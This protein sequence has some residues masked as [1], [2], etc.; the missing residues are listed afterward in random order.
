MNRTHLA[1]LVK[2]GVV[3]QRDASPSCSVSQTPMGVPVPQAGRVC[4]AMKVWASHTLKK[5]GSSRYTEDSQL[6]RHRCIGHTWTTQS[7]VY[8]EL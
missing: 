1:E 7:A 6:P 8:A 3:N 4:S 5:Q 2:K